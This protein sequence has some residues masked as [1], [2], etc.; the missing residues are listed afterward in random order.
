MIRYPRTHTHMRAHM[1]QVINQQI[2]SQFRLDETFKVLF[3]LYIQYTSQK[4]TAN[5]Q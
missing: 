3:S 2:Q 1:N 5:L 4:Y